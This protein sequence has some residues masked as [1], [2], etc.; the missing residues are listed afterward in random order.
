MEQARIFAAAGVALALSFALTPVAM[1]LAPIVGAVDVPLDGRRMH[2]SPV[3]RMGGVAIFFAFLV[4]SASLG[5][6]QGVLARW[7]LGATLLVLLGIF[8]DVYRLPAL[9]KLIVQLLAAAIAVSGGGGVAFLR[10]WDVQISL[11]A[12]RVPLSVVW[13]IASINAHNMI[14]GLD[15]LSASVSTVEAFVL[16]VMFALQGNGALSGASLLV[17][18]ACLGYL[19]YNRHPA[20]V[21]MGDT[22]SQFLGFMLGL[23]SLSIDQW[24]IG[25][26]G[27]LAP[28][29]VVALPLSDLGFAVVRRVARGQ[30]PFAADRGHWHHRLIDAGLSQRQVCFWMVL[31]TAQLGGIAILVSREEW[32]GYAVYAVLWVIVALM[33]MRFLYGRWTKQA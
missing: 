5:M 11:G 20:R 3:P 26:L 16:S 7:L 31:L 8:D 29:L 32:Y 10:L 22:G 27:V 4:P 28:V 13:L 6:A 30:S 2:T 21:F 25:S 18:G 19:P 9:S 17:C 14:D 33:G 15:G 24:M 1:R 23:L 12:W